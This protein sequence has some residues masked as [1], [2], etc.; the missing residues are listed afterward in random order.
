[1]IQ[2]PRALGKCNHFF[3]NLLEGSCCQLLYAMEMIDHVV[4][5][6]IFV[7]FVCSHCACIFTDQFKDM[8]VRLTG[9]R[10]QHEWLSVSVGQ[11]YYFLANLDTFNPK[12]TQTYCLKA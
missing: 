1:M 8:Q 6:G 12:T 7:E 11:P 10:C 3:L 9:C 4:I 2:S 5:V